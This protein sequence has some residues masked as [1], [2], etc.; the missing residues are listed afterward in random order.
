M[1]Q[2]SIEEGLYQQVEERAE[3]QGQ[4]PE[5]FIAEAIRNRIYDIDNSEPPDSEKR[6]RRIGQ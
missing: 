1:K 2:I 5:E 4:T 6:K 3:R